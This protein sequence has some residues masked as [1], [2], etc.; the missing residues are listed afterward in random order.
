MSLI[1]ARMRAAVGR[2]LSRSTSF[3]V[4]ESD[5]RRWVIATYYPEPPPARFWDPAVAATTRDGGITAPQEF[6]PFAWMKAAQQTASPAGQP[7]G[8]AGSADFPERQLGIPGPGLSNMLNGGV[9]VEYGAL[10]RPGDVIDSVLT[11]ASYTE[12]SGR[13]GAMLLTVTE[14]HWTNQRGAT[15]RRSRFTLIR[16]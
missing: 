14:D 5:I 10:M 16:Y 1:S 9:A 15:V 3:P 6:N 4:S 11:L 12:K 8:P 7:A 13:L 2:E